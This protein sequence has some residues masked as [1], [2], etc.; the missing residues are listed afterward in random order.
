MDN[1]ARAIDF[2][3][4]YNVDGLRLR[5]TVS[6]TMEPQYMNVYRGNALGMVGRGRNRPYPNML[7][8]EGGGPGDYWRRQYTTVELPLI[9]P[10]MSPHVLAG[11]NSAVNHRGPRHYL[12]GLFGQQPPPGAKYLSHRLWSPYVTLHNEI[13]SGPYATFD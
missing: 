6:Y 3:R 12:D 13:K 7:N 4:Q 2:R 10:L 1:R 11:Y 5:P 8:T 9:A